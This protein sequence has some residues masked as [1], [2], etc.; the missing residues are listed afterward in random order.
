MNGAGTHGGFY[1]VPCPGTSNSLGISFAVAGEDCG[2]AVYADD[3]SVRD[4]QELLD[5]FLAVYRQEI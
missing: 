5:D 2:M 1:Y 4:P 3:N